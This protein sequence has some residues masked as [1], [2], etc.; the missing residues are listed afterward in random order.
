MKY[1]ALI[2]RILFS[3]IFIFSGIS[4]FLAATI[5][6]ATMVGVPMASFLVPLSGLI[7]LAGGLSIAFGYKAKFGAVLI[8]IFLLPVTF[9]MHRFWGISDPMMAQ[10]QMAMFMKNIALTGG[11]L[12]IAA[13]GSGPLS[14]DNKTV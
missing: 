13:F 9:M 2:G 7:A 5:G 10:V 11:A 6:Y 3:L 8:I 12:I 1:T 4:H 14:L